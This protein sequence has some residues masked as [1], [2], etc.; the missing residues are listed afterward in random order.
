VR[1]QT[2]PSCTC[3][4]D[5]QCVSVQVCMRDV[6]CAQIGLKPLLSIVVTCFHA[7]DDI[8]F[9]YESTP[10][11]RCFQSPVTLLY[12][13]T[14]LGA[15]SVYCSTA[16]GAFSIQSS[17]FD[18]GKPSCVTSSTKSWFLSLLSS[19][20]ICTSSLYMHHDQPAHVNPSIYTSRM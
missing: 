6:C 18:G 17:T 5:S 14:A 16:L 13:S 19:S 8:L 20:S 9:V 3:L 11:L 10:S 1:L 4:P 2:C 7:F 12:C 15:F